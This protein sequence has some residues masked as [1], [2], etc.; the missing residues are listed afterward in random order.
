MERLPLNNHLAQDKTI[1][2]F[3]A[4]IMALCLI[5]AS[6]PDTITFPGPD[7][8]TVDNLIIIEGLGIVLRNL[9]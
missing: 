6:A 8:P 3:I 7:N 5:K 9:G 1:R 4:L 2:A